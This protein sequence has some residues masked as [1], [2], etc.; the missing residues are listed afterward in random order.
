M[1]LGTHVATPAAAAPRRRGKRKAEKLGYADALNQRCILELSGLRPEDFVYV[2]L[3]NDG[4]GILPFFVARDPAS[5]SVILSVRG[6]NSS[7]DVLTDIVCEMVPLDPFFD[8]VDR[9]AWAGNGSRVTSRGAG[10]PGNP[11]GNPDR[12]S[13]F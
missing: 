9:L 11:G 1:P 4:M 2:N 13:T 10:G 12:C 6:T 7:V 8:R 3:V 5:R